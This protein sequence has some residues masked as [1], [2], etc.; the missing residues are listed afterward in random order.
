VLVR[1]LWCEKAGVML[2]DN[3]IGSV[4][5]IRSAPTFQLVTRRLGPASEWHSLDRSTNNEIVP[6]FGAILIRPLACAISAIKLRWSLRA[7]RPLLDSAFQLT[8][9]SEQCVLRLLSL[10]ISRR[11]ASGLGSASA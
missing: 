1:I 8:F 3:F 6:R 11:R 10:A 9:G 7:P 5:L 2:A 4:S